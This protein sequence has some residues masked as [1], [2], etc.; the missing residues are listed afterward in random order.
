[1]LS[2][3]YGLV[4]VLFLQVI[5]Y[6]NCNNKLNYDEEL[7]K[8][9]NNFREFSGKSHIQRNSS[10]IGTLFRNNSKK[11]SGFS[12]DNLNGIIKIDIDNKWIEVGGKT[13]YYDILKHTLKYNLMPKLVPEL[14]SITV[15]GAISGISIESSSFK[16][17]W[18]HDSVIDMDVL[19]S[20]GEVLFTN[21]TNE[22]AD[23]FNAIPNSYGTLG[24]VTRVKLE[25]IEAKPF[26][27]LKNIKFNSIE[28]AFK[29]LN[30]AINNKDA[31]FIDAVVYS[32]NNV[33]VVLGF[34]C[35][36]QDSLGIEKCELS[37]YPRNGIYYESVKRMRYDCMTIYDYLWRWDADMFWGATDIS[38]LNNKWFRWVF[39][40]CIL[41]TRVLR[42]AQKISRSCK[43]E[44]NN[45]KIIQ[46]LG[47]PKENAVEFL[48]WIC[49][50]IHKYPIWICPVI[51]K[52]SDSPLWSFNNNTLYY[53]IGVFVRKK[54]NIEPYYYN[55][56][57]E[58]KLLELD[59]NKC[60]YSDTF[61][62][63]S[64]FNSLVDSKK[65]ETLKNKYD[66][67]NRFN[68]LYE[69]VI[70]NEHNVIT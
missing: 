53:D 65:Y 5:E 12:L 21:R 9:L 4:R 25:L 30:I 27:K 16:Y 1:M 38:I 23:L 28:D 15:G 68:N 24:Y 39:G 3:I 31:D 55:K 48:K 37:N 69:K 11:D 63:K 36:D 34:M 45:E 41:N 14:S 18:G 20:S 35:D 57:I 66:P 58:K 33:V 62:N 6:F 42:S 52:E 56:L 43:K 26:V 70:H 54:Q 40:R 13:R 44:N 49:N 67:N 32:Q 22:N 46:D 47:I 2:N 29:T 50:N 8:T 64:D 60:F 7:V 19:I 61:F 10:D 17:G 51:P 59:G